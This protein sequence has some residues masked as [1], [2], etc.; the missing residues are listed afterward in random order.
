M[1]NLWR[2]V[3]PAVLAASMSAPADAA[4]STAMLP[5]PA[6][7]AVPDVTP[8]TDPKV[9]DQGYKFYY[10]HNPSVSFA[11]AYQ[12]LKECRAHLPVGGP[13]NVPGFVPWDEAHRRKV[14][15]GFTAP[16]V[17][18]AVVYSAI[19][20]VILPKMERGVRSNKMRRCMGT[21]G[22]DRYA[23]PESVWDKLNDADE[24]Q[25]I[26]MQAKLASGPKPQDVAVTR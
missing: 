2:F 21:R 22:Y 24:E 26:L 17:A 3:M 9:R 1:R 6:A 20:A 5:D 8:S 4:D 14:Y 19:A 10:F 18:H 25:L 16:S 15:E 7:I 11:E 23:I 13:A 12:D